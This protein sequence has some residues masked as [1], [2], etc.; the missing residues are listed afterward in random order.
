M[1]ATVD[2]FLDPLEPEEMVPIYEYEDIDLSGV[3]W[4]YRLTWNDRAERW[5]IDVWSSDGKKAIYGKRLI[6][7]YPLFWANE[8]RR[9]E[10]G[11]ILLWDT[12]DPEADEQCTYEGL[13]NRWI[14]CWMVDDGSTTTSDRPW[15]ITLP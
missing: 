4:N 15:A 8:G 11:Y 6:P 2:K 7:N 13:G 14:L 1:A 5:T 10:G 9:P 12:G 3:S